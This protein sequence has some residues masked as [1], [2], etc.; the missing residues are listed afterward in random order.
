MAKAKEPD[1]EK[2]IIDCFPAARISYSIVSQL[3]LCLPIESVDT[4]MEAVEEIEIEGQKLPAAV[5]RKHL[6]ADLFPIE[7]LEDL[8]EKTCRGVQRGLA[9]ANSP[10]TQF[11]RPEVYKILD[12]A[13]PERAKSAGI[14]IGFRN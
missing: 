9:I 14:G 12:S 2:L 6:G 1:I 7:T 11:R 8:T 5:F 13:F 3:Q 4:L 10:T